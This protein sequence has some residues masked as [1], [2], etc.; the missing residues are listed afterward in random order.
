MMRPPRIF[1]ENGD[2]YSKLRR[3]RAI[4]RCDVVE[5][6]VAERADLLTYVLYVMPTHVVKS[7]HTSNY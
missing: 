5:L 3:H 1:C 2:T 7:N 6:M 4:S